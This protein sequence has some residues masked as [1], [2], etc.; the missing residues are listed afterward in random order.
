MTDM[1]NL[2]GGALCLDFV[3]TVD[4][5]HAPDR[6]EYLDSYPALTAWGRYA[7]AAAGQGDRPDKAAA[8][9]PVG[10]GGPVEAGGS[11]EADGC[12]VARSGCGKLFTRCSAGPP[13]D[14]RPILMTSA[15]SRPS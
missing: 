5:R 9:D 15:C 13:G 6:R 3:N 7:E 4:P 11:F 8:G 12:W 2:V 1:P 10:A 14:S